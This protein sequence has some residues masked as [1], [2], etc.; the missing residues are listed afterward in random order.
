MKDTST[1]TQIVDL[2]DDDQTIALS[3]LAYDAQLAILEQ[4]HVIELREL[5]MMLVQGA[6]CTPRETI[7]MMGVN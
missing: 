5:A 3:K 1:T 6:G 7:Y 4:R 2:N